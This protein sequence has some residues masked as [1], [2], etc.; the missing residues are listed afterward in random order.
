MLVDHY[1]QS[2]IEPRMR[3]IDALCPVPR[4]GEIG[5]GHI[6]SAT[7]RG[8]DQGT[9]C[10]ERV[11]LATNALRRRQRLPKLDRHPGKT[12]MFLDD[13]GRA[14]VEPD[15]DGLTALMRFLRDDRGRRE[16]AA[17]HDQVERFPRQEES[18]G[19]RRAHDLRRSSLPL[20]IACGKGPWRIH[21]QV[22]W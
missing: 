21:R 18:S 22:Q 12:T 13:E 5:N 19:Y 9:N 10:W 20:T 15:F 3:E 7:R 6:D 17:N 8:V 11:V 16:E 4:N 14:Y 2:G 1:A